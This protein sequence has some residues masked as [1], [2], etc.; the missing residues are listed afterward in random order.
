MK[1]L[2]T[3]LIL[4]ILLTGCATSTKI[5]PILGTE[6][7]IISEKISENIEDEIFQK[8]ME[9][10]KL[11]ETIERRISEKEKKY[12]DLNQEWWL[13]SLFFSPKLNSCLYIEYKDYLSGDLYEKWLYDVLD[14]S[15]SSKTINSCFKSI[16]EIEG[17]GCEKFDQKIEELKQA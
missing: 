14:D 6:T 11:R 16:T 13:E 8:N 9:C 2:F 17:S 7:E 3:A 4:A 5:E 12:G 10:L 15:S 1:K